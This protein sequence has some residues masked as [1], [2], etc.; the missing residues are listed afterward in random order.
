MN[1]SVATTPSGLRG[2]LIR[3]M[4]PV[5]TIAIAQLFGTSLWFSANSTA[6]ELMSAWSATSTDIGWLTNAV[7]LGFILGTLSLSL[8]GAA[9]RFRASTLFVC[10]AIAGALFNLGFAWLAEGLLSGG[11]LRFGVG[12]TLAGI[13]PMGMKLIVGWAPERTGLA[14]AQLVAMLTLGTALPHALRMVGANWPWQAIITASS[15]LALAGAVLIG[16]LGEGPHARAGSAP[17]AAKTQRA[18][19]ILGAFRISRFRA[20]TLGYFGHMWEL[21]AF[22]TLVPLIVSRTG[23]ASS[24]PALGVAG[25]SFCIM[26]LGAVGSIL[27]GVLSQR[28]GSAKV[29]LGALSLSGTC[30]LLFV[31]CA[32]YLPVWALLALLGIWG[33]SV[34]AD[35]PQFSAL[36]AQACPRDAVGSALAIQNSIGF[37]ITVVSIAVTS[38]LFERIGIDALWLLVPGPVLGV[39]GFILSS[40][41]A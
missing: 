21:Y 8:S 40:R 36:A 27:G 41:Q 31:L 39:S 22:W 19:A 5:A 16:V 28:T 9:D 33:A 17:E 11:V 6:E 15:V 7:Q 12:I 26:A 2:L 37:A 29:A 4:G 1:L 38:W 34:V 3:S 10:S 32:D 24:F 13:Y 18:G 25:L 20:A 35:S 14:L 23:L 30:G